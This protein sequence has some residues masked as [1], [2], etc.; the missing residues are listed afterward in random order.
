MYIYL[1]LS[2]HI[3]FHVMLSHESKKVW[4]YNAT[5]LYYFVITGM[6]KLFGKVR[7]M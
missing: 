2:V 5:N 6:Y 3:R 1:H 4:T 7:S